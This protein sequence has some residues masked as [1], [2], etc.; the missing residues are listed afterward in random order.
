MTMI[1]KNFTISSRVAITQ[2]TNGAQTSE[3]VY[4]NPGVS[5]EILLY[6]NHEW[7]TRAKPDIGHMSVSIEI[8][9]PPNLTPS[10]FR[11]WLRDTLIDMLQD[12]PEA[13]KD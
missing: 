5:A 8:E 1:L 6:P 4:S 10:E 12:K 3:T 7:K 2:E 13:S 11:V 9:Q